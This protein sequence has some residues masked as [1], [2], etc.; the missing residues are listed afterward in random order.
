MT[1]R[2][3]FYWNL[4]MAKHYLKLYPKPYTSLGFTNVLIA[5][6]ST[7]SLQILP[8]V[9]YSGIFWCEESDRDLT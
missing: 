3:K 1:L 4:R 2:L 8:I 6:F 9:A 7:K 5:V